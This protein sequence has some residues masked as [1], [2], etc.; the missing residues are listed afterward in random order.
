MEPSLKYIWKIIH[1]RGE[2]PF[3]LLF[4]LIPFLAIHVVINYIRYLYR[5]LKFI[6][7]LI[8]NNIHL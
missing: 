4:N 7:Q 6:I 2:Q 8:I 5:T 1:R 3:Q